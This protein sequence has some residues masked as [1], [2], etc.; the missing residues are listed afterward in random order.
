MP[1]S[2]RRRLSMN[3]SQG[4]VLLALHAGYENHLG[5]LGRV[6]DWRYREDARPGLL[7]RA[8]DIAQRVLRGREPG[9]VE[10]MLSFHEE[11]EWTPHGY[12]LARDC[13]VIQVQGVLA[14]NGYWDFWDDCFNSGY[15][16]IAE[17]IRAANEDERV[18]AVMLLIDSPGGLS[19][20]TDELSEMM[21]A[22]RQGSGGKPLVAFCHMAYSAA[23]QI[24]ASCDA[25]YAPRGAGLG[26]IGVRMGWFDWS[27]MM[28]ED[29]VKR[30][31]FKSGEFKDMGSPFRE[32]TESER[33]MFQAQ[34]DAHAAF[35]FE[36]VA[37]GRGISLETVK[38]WQ[39]RTFTAGAEG[40]LDPV[41]AGLLDAVLNEDEAFEAA[42]A[43]AG[44]TPSSEAASGRAASQTD[45]AAATSKKELS[46]SIEAEIAALR[47]KAAKGDA[48]AIDR[49]KSLGVSVK[50]PRSDG[51]ATP[52]G[53]G[54]DPDEV[55]EEED[56]DPEAENDEDDPEAETDPEDPEA[57]DEDEPK[58][59]A[60]AG[61][62]IGRIAARDGKS[63]LGCTLA[64]DVAAGEMRYATALRTLKSAT[65]EGSP[66]KDAMRGRGA[67]V[68]PGRKADDPKPDAERNAG[69]GRA[70]DR[71]LARTKR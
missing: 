17:A 52:K 20:G 3:A 46:M 23:Q 63:G 53:E 29:K 12:Y 33:A 18:A 27:G 48:K 59:L 16:D 19:Y 70:M 34:I 47:A 68:K 66:L 31:E 22:N 64:A 67:G 15:A 38:G 40:D 4:A 58:S 30:E 35:F 71:V 65:R 54:D 49:L 61:R 44:L 21:Q 11:A 24:A 36:A 8:G 60:A 14:R 13:A 6:A 39:A 57:E 9:G 25:C 5:R 45:P 69:L 51:S 62:K 56:T 28:A 10:S 50:P 41:A 55:S 1:R 42:R 7:D 37:T 32:V 26:S 2:L 43:L